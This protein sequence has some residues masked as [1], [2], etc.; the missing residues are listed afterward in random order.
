LQTAPNMSH[1]E[2]REE[3]ASKRNVTIRLSTFNI[4]KS[5]P[6]LLRLYLRS[7]LRF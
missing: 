2:H 4:A 6:L 1:R 3:N 7:G 5:V